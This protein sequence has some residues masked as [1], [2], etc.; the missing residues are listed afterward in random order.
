GSDPTFASATPIPMTANT[1]EIGGVTYN[2][3]EVTFAD[4]DFFTFGAKLSGPGGVTAGLLM[5][6]K[7]DD[8]TTEEGTTGVWK[9]VSGLGRDVTQNNNAAYQP[10]LVTDASYTADSKEYH[11]N[12]NPFY[13]FDGSNDFF[14]RL[15][16]YF[17]DDE[18]P[19]SAYG[20]MFNAA[21]SGW[22]TP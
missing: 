12:Y 2:Y 6:H 4:G 3:A 21:V 18:G 8:G 22:R 19:G 9:D 10:S 16:E 17:T 15:D 5:W 7:A 14:Y 11:F 1:V 20:V 13:Y